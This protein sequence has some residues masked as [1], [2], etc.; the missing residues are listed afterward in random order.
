MAGGTK[1]FR[2]LSRDSAHRRA[3][4]RNL[5][6]S[7][8]KN[9]SIHTTYAKAKEAQRMA[10][11]LITLAKRDNEPARRHAQSILF[12]RPP[13]HLILQLPVLVPTLT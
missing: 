10:E 8:I 13:F 1:P 3:L 6:T 7:L 2:G 12:V 11:K 4:L 5:V 9:E